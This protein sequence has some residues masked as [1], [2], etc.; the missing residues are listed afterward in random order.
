MQSKSVNKPASSDKLGALHE[1]LA[2]VIAAQVSERA[3]D[4][5]EDG[6]TISEYYT[7]TP[8]LLTV[9]ARFL[10]DNDI[11]C[12]EEDSEGLS[13]LAEELK[14]KKKRGKVAKISHIDEAAYG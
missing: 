2:I 5:D 1:A 7:A 9:A 8:A 11:T 10:K 12:T 13:D 6:V 3:S 4:I 14:K